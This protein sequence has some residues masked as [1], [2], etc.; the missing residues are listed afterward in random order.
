MTDSRTELRFNFSPADFFE[1]GRRMTLSSGEL[2]LTDG[3][4]TILLPAP[5]NPV[6]SNVI[7][8]ARSELAALLDLQS[9]T[10]R[11]LHT[12]GAGATIQQHNFAGT[13]HVMIA[14]TGHLQLSG[15]AVS[16]TVQV[17]SLDGQIISDSGELKRQADEKFMVDVLPKALHSSVL[18]KLLESFKA[19]IEDPEDELVHLYEIIDALKAHFGTETAAKNA[20]PNATTNIN[21]IGK[22]STIGR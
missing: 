20:F 14:G 22:L 4:A 17:R 9:L 10:T 1:P 2:T 11:R 21:L 5:L 12:L 6:P 19:S 13:S 8:D 16:A 15:S 7:E 18:R 3:T